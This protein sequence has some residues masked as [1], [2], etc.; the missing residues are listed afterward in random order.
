MGGSPKGLPKS[1]TG[2][3]SRASTATM[4]AAI[5]N[6]RFRPTCQGSFNTLLL[7]QYEVGL[8]RAACDVKYRHLHLYSTK[9]AIVSRHLQLG[10]EPAAQARQACPSRC[11][12][13]SQRRWA[14]ARP[15][16]RRKPQR[17]FNSCARIPEVSP[18]I[19]SM[20]DGGVSTGRYQWPQSARW[21]LGRSEVGLGISALH[22]W[23]L[24]RLNGPGLNG[25]LVLNM[26]PRVL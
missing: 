1:R 9:I 21:S 22:T 6:L 2:S 12:V 24:V 13:A 11:A 25:L 26:P 3:K 5:Q 7:L 16:A 17:R 15:E 18:R 4:I 20:P 19:W 14:E 8:P 10:G 23:L